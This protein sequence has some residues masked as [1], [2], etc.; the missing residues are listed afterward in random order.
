MTDQISYDD[1]AKVDIRV[2]RI[3]EAEPFPEARKPAFKLR[4]DFGPDIGVKRSSA[5]ITRHYTIEELIGR[6]VLAVVNFP[7]RQIGPVRS[8]VLVLGVP[9]EAGE[10]VLLS[11]GHDVPLAGKMF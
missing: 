11:P 10:V 7:P 9:D 1:F 6:Q 4:I 8:E 3:I 2:G 5:Q